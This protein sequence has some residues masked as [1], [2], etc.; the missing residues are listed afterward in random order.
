[1]YLPDLEEVKK[2]IKDD[3]ES[4][5]RRLEKADAIVGPVDSYEFVDL[6]MKQVR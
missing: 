5:T 2:L 6:F 4:F 3:S 1:M